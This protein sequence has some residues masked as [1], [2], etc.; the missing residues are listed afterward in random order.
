VLLSVRH[1]VEVDRS[2]MVNELHAEGMSGLFPTLRTDHKIY[3]EERKKSG[4][5]PHRR[6]DLEAAMAN[7]QLGPLAPRV[8]A[9]IDRHLAELPPVEARDKDDVTWQ[10]ALHR[11][12]LRQYD[13]A[14]PQPSQEEAAT[15]PAGE[16]PPRQYIRLEPKA[17]APEVQELIDERAKTHDAMNA[18]LGAYLWGL[19]LLQRE[20]GRADPSQ[21]AEKLAA[22]QAL[23]RD[24]EHPDSTRNAPGF[25]AAVCVRDHWDGTSPEQKDWCVDVVRSEIAR[26]AGQWGTGHFGPHPEIR[27]ASAA[28]AERVLQPILD[29]V[30]RHPREVHNPG[31][32]EQRGQPSE[33]RALLVLVA[34]ARPRPASSGV[35]SPRHA[36]G[37]RS[38]GRIQNAG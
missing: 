18:R 36:G 22:A 34:Q 8:H 9:I 28:D 2:R 17:P 10:L 33:H 4:E 19:Q 37:K 1:Y 11:M 12:D 30:D 5:L 35:V 14:A 26:Q 29:A 23:E 3:E 20:S 24:S 32:Y 31:A 27:G 15:P 6:M 25:V 21:W 16:E 13:V 38:F 7:L